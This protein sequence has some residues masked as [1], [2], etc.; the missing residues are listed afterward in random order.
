MQSPLD[1]LL[2]E[3]RYI[4]NGCKL[5]GGTDEVGRGPLAGPVVC[6]L[7]IMP[8]NDII[9]GVTD[10]KLLSEKKRLELSEIIR[11]KAYYYNIKEVSVEKID[12]I[13]I[14]NA[15]KLCMKKC[16][17][18]AEIKPDILLIDAL[19]LNIDIP[20]ESIIE[21]DLKSYS[22][23]CASI[24]AKVYR[25]NLMCKFAEKYPL[26]GFEKHKGYGTELHISRLKQYGACEIH[27]QSFIK[28]I[29]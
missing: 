20:S 15:T 13:N 18:E 6:A 11:K 2:Y 9:E 27:R 1:N 19:K 29:V 24:I 10:S 25:D 28:N 23:A 26:Y 16:I 7:A 4:K 14:L 21:G 22:I 3:K 5:I 17:D 12:E 8:L